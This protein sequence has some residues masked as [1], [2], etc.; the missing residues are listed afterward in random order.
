MV[1][2][3]DLLRKAA[4]FLRSL[5]SEHRSQL[6]DKLEVAQVAAVTSAMDGLDEIGN[7]ERESVAR[8][9]QGESG[10]CSEGHAEEKTAPFE[11]LH[12][13]T[14]DDLRDLLAEEQP[15]TIALVLSYLPPCLA[16]ELLDRLTPELQFSVICRIATL[17]EPDVEIVQEV[18]NV[19]KKRLFGGGEHAVVHRGVANVIRILHAMTP[20]NERKLLSTLSEAE[21]QLV[22]EIRRGMF[23]VDVPIFAEADVIESAG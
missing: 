16:G 8:E 10:Q 19:L 14:P 5:P 21:P 3:Q 11:F 1:N 6:L 22:R 18:E 9:F 12:D 15:Q 4:V 2:A 7:S 23:G 13:R 20:A 17:N